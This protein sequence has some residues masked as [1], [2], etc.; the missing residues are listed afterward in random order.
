VYG[1]DDTVFFSDAAL[2]LAST[3]DPDLPYLV[4]DNMWFS[5]LFE[6]AW[7]P[8]PQVNYHPFSGRAAA[9]GGGG[10]DNPTVC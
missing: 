5:A 2:K 7:H 1:D 10:G 9:G 8:H 3:M 4:T 6:G